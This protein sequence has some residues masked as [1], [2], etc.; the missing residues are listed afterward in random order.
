MSLVRLLAAGLLLALSA[1]PGVA[2][3]RVTPGTDPSPA[4]VVPAAAISERD[5]TTI[6]G[7]FARLIAVGAC[8]QG[9]ARSAGSCVSPTAVKSWKKGQ[10]LPST[11]T[12]FPLPN[13][14]LIQLRTPVGYQ[15]VRVLDDVL[16]ITQGTRTVVDAVTDLR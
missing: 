8:P 6:R 10:P 5:Q 14:L 3:R 12:A 11:P 4:A 13:D 15:Y 9:L 16:L 1:S 2:Q 7:H